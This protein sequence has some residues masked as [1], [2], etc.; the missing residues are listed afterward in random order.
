[1]SDK[2]HPRRIFYYLYALMGLLAH[3]QP[4]HASNTA[5]NIQTDYHCDSSSS[6]LTL[7]NLARAHSWTPLPEG[8]LNAGFTDGAC[9]I[10]ILPDHQ[11]LPD[12]DLI[13]HVDYPHLSSVEVFLLKPS[14]PVPIA[15]L[16]ARKPF[17]ERLIK[18]PTFA[19]PVSAE[20]LGDGMLVLKIDSTSTMT[21]PVSLWSTE[22]FSEFRHIRTL[23]AGSLLGMLTGLGL[24][25]LILSLQ[26]RERSVFYVVLLNFSLAFVILVL[27]GHGFEFLWPKTP[28]L[29]EPLVSASI[30]ISV[31]FAMLFCVE[32]LE[33]KTTRPVIGRLLLG[34][35]LIGLLSTIGAFLLPYELSTRFSVYLALVTSIFVTWSFVARSLDRFT[36]A[37][38]LLVNA[39]LM[40][41]GIGL[42]SFASFGLIEPSLITEHAATAALSSQLLVFSLAMGSRMNLDKRVREQAQAQLLEAQIALTDRLDHLVTER[43]QELESANSMLRELSVRDGL[44]GLYNRRFFDERCEQLFRRCQRERQVIS[45][46]VI[47]ID[48]FKQ[49]NDQFGHDAGDE[50]IIQVTRLIQSHV[51]RP[52]DISVRLGGEEFG[53]LLPGT[54][55]KGATKVA[56]AIRASVESL[57]VE[58]DRH[59]IYLTLSLGVSACVPDSFE[60]R[61]G[62]LRYTDKLLYEAKRNGRNQVQAAEYQ[63]G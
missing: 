9:W 49:I 56:E 46:L 29:N 40:V 32:I 63:P 58:F 10:R 57:R 28:S 3:F 42:T 15:S 35:G 47:D 61:L 36:P 50:C 38:F 21:V 34:L 44:T 39:A 11:S 17:N 59:A 26:I 37:Y 62:V 31:F 24:Y 16:G 33:L 30:S 2:T 19:I 27:G 48:H 14:G 23:I 20:D 12:S 13:L 6:Q 22:S 52:D 8:R 43:T 4:A 51:S 5:L 54:D 55:L 1:M 7:E 25:H 53:V 60:D 45:I 41:F 18:I